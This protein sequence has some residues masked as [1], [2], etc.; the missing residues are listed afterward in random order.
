[1][2]KSSVV[3]V[4]GITT[5]TWQSPYTMQYTLDVQRQITPTMVF[6][7]PWWVRGG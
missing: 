1:M 4:S 3:Y 2:K 5:L 7:R 6:K